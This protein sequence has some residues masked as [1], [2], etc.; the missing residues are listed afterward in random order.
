MMSI[1][2]GNIALLNIKALIIG[3]LLAELAK[4]RPYKRN[5]KCQFDWKNWKIIKHKNLLS[6]TK[7]DKEILT[8]GDIEIGNNKL[9]WHKCLSF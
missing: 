2:L 1:I 3:L 9:Y 8:F 6:N 5:A 7:I 4:I